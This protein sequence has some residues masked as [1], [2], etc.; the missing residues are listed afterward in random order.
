MAE[1]TENIEMAEAYEQAGAD[2]F[3]APTP[4]SSLTSDPQ[5]PRAWETPPE[6]NTEEEALK[7]I[8]MNLTDEDNH[9]QLL[10]SLRDGNPIEMIVQ[11]IL[12]KGF[13]EGNWSPDLMLLLVE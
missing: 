2:M 3:D 6:F 13:Q 5:N 12:F 9:E 11:V 8:F 10:N 7:N 4:G 1:N